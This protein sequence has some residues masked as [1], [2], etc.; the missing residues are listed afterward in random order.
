MDFEGT[1]SAS[2]FRANSVEDD[3]RRSCSA[4]FRT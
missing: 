2:Q 1:T 3:V 4:A